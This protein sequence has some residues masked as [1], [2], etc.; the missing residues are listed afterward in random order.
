MAITIKHL[1]GPLK[2]ERQSFDDSTAT[3]LVGRSAG[4]QVTY[5][6]ECTA[7]SDEHVQLNRNEGGD[8]TIE[9]P[10]AGY[11]EIDGKLAADNAKVTSGSIVRVGRGGPTFEALM[12]GV[13]IQHLEG[14]LKGQ[15]QHFGLDA[16]TITFGRPDQRT[17]IS[18]PQTYDSVGRLHFSLKKTGPGTYCVLLTPGHYVAVNGTEAD[19]NAVVQSGSTFRLGGDTGPSFSVVI[20]QPQVGGIKTKPNKPQTLVRKELHKTKQ[21]GTYALATLAVLIFALGGYASYRNWRYDQELAML[22]QDITDAKAKAS[23]LAENEIPKDATKALQ[24]AVYLVAK[25]EGGGETPE[26]TAWAFAS[27]KL[28]TN[29]HVTEAIKGHEKEFE[30]IAPN[31]DRI[32]IKSVTSHPAYLIFSNYKGTQ[33]KLRWGKFKPLDLINEYDVGIIDIDPETPLPVDSVTGKPVTLELAPVDHVKALE[34]GA[35]VASVGFPTENVAASTV[36]VEAPGTL[37]F[38]NIS[39][40]TDVFMCRA[41]QDHRLLIQHSVPVTGGASGSPLIDSSGKV[42]GIVNGGNATVFKDEKQSANDKLRIPSAVLINFA[43]RIDS[44]VDLADGEAAQNLAADRF[45]WEAAAQKFD[46]YFEGAAKDFVALAAERYGVADAT[47]VEI[48]KGTLEPRK[49]GALS[50]VSASYQFEAEPGHVYG[51]I[52]EAKSGVLIGINVKKKGT[53]EFL[54]DEK[55]PRK[56]NEPELAP[57][58]WLTVKEKTPVEIDVGSLTSQP[59]DYVLRAY[60]WDEP[61]PAGPS[62]ADAAATGPQP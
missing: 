33:G 40:L 27:D 47:T 41:D 21:Q 2:G 56:T 35:A 9:L 26:A 59:A 54:R 15:H 39:S 32:D 43:L 55:D 11:V 52:A 31:G 18:Y 1:D 46:S 23:A 29:A 16:D 36:A 51:F 22:T 28:A 14:P 20:E 61:N 49:A 50:F 42:I 24:A 53:S 13:T 8:Y 58:V 38:G 17:D 4:A 10:S 30:L 60:I 34:P 44:L 7:V 6:E 62:A 3:I 12:P 19:N 5:P 48:G 57:T 45:Y 37:H 25:K